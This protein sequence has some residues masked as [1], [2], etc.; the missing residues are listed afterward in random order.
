MAWRRASQRDA[1]EAAAGY[2][3]IVAMMTICAGREHAA[4]RRGRKS[5]FMHEKLQ[6]PVALVCFGLCAMVLITVA[7]EFIVGTRARGRAATKLDFLTALVG[8][9]LRNKRRYG[10]YLVHVGIVLMFF[11][12]AGQT[13]QAENEVTLARGKSTTLG[14]YEITLHQLPQLLGPAEGGHRGAAAGESRRAVSQFE[15]RPAKWAYRGHEEEPPRTIVA[16]HNS[17]FED[18]YMIL[19]G[20]DEQRVGRRPEA[21]HQPAG[22]VGV[23]RLCDADDWHGGGVLAR[24]QRPRRQRLAGAG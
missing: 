2:P 6:L 11:G 14:R 15:L 20:I 12:F 9:L 4:D 21:D 19:N 23:A 18:L 24:P 13:F 10:G 8:L 7:Q 3:V 17:L 1:V 16:T 22:A 5:S